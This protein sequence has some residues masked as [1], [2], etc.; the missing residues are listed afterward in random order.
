MSSVQ[1]M[2]R[3][4]LLLTWNCGFVCICKHVYLL[5]LWRIVPNKA[6]GGPRRAVAPRPNYIPSACKKGKIKF[7]AMCV[8]SVGLFAQLLFHTRPL[9]IHHFP[10]ILQFSPPLLYNIL[11]VIYVLCFLPQ[12]QKSRC[13]INFVFISFL[14]CSIHHWRKKKR[15][16]NRNDLLYCF[17]HIIKHDCCWCI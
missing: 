10:L 12:P 15:K 3:A 6:G 17:C 11:R 5:R 16:N 4:P 8:F 13:G 1:R 9:I 14:F 7:P 2:S